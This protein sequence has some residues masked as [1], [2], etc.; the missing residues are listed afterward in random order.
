[1]EKPFDSRALLAGTYEFK[2]CQY[3]NGTYYGTADSNQCRKGNEVSAKDIQ[4]DVSKKVSARDYSLQKIKNPTSKRELAKD[5]DRIEALGKETGDNITSQTIDKANAD[6]DKRRDEILGRMNRNEI[7]AQEIDDFILKR[8]FVGDPKTA[9]TLVIGI[10]QTLPTATVNEGGKGYDRFI[11]TQMATQQLQAEN[12]SQSKQYDLAL[13]LKEEKGSQFTGNHARLITALTGDTVSSIELT[14]GLKNT[15]G[16]ELRSVPANRENGFELGQRPWVKNN[17]ALD[18]KVGSDKAGDRKNYNANYAD[19]MAKR[20]TDTV[21]AAVRDNPNL[22]TIALGLGKNEPARDQIL[23]DIEKIPGSKSRSFTYKDSQGATVQGTIIDVGGKGK[24]HVYDYGQSVNARGFNSGQVAKT[25]IEQRQRLD[26]GRVKSYDRAS[27]AIKNQEYVANAKKNNA[28]A[29]AAAM[30]G[31]STRNLKK[32]LAEPSMG[33]T[34][35]NNIRKE[36]ERREGKA[37]ASPTRDA[38]RNSAPKNKAPVTKETNRRKT[39]GKTE[40]EKKEEEAA[41]RARKQKREAA[42]KKKKERTIQKDL[43]EA[44]ELRK[45]AKPGSQNYQDAN[46]AVKEFMKELEALK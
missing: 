23:R 26:S 4:E 45:N 34:K 5:I 44:R 25:F 43:N 37:P 20:L 11:A 30:E 12:P 40:T 14:T 39:T 29:T 13:G 15:A 31:V 8:N 42:E 28:Q 18:A 33:P 9:E 10:E 41:K 21:A 19:P 2:T 7:T 36:I 17:P 6:I 32:A 35:K 27:T 46:N 3:P 16:M 24:T 38:P 1:V 22:K